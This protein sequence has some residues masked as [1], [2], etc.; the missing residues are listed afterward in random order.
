MSPNCDTLYKTLSF[1]AECSSH[2]DCCEN[3]HRSEYGMNPNMC[4]FGT[5][6]DYEF[7]MACCTDTIFAAKNL[8]ARELCPN[9]ITGQMEACDFYVASTCCPGGSGL[10]LPLPFLYEFELTMPIAPRGVMYFFSP[11]LAFHGGHAHIGY[12]HDRNRGDYF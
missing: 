10:V 7:A 6:K 2:I 3:L 11:L 1:A 8:T 4:A 12:V 9:V 5:M